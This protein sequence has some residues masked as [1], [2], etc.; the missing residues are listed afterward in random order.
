M[1]GDVHSNVFLEENGQRHLFS[2][3]EERKE[4]LLR[5]LLGHA[6]HEILHDRHL[7]PDTRGEVFM[8]GDRP[9]AVATAVD[10]RFAQLVKHVLTKLGGEGRRQGG[11]ESDEELLLDILNGG[12]ESV[13]DLLSLLAGCRLV[14]WLTRGARGGLEVTHRGGD[15]IAHDG[16]QV[17]DEGREVL[18]DDDGGALDELVD[19]A[20]GG[21]VCL[22]V[23][24]SARGSGSESVQPCRPLGLLGGGDTFRG[25]RSNHGCRRLRRRP[26]RRRLDCSLGHRLSW[27]ARDGEGGSL[28]Q[29]DGEQP[30]GNRLCHG[31]V[32]L[33]AEGLGPSGERVGSG[34]SG[35]GGGL[36]PRHGA[37]HRRADVHAT[38]A[39]LHLPVVCYR[40]DPQAHARPPPVS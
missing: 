20:G 38:L 8:R 23:S 28:L 12:V 6:H 15:P 36:Q 17:L 27:G 5:P 26:G 30:A 1:L 4:P 24:S 37:R 19:P 9:E 35:G 7:L 31:D 2:L 22:H 40:R 33:T 32:D 25:R 11:A 18:V 13:E 16:A 3:E 10:R 29:S 14:E 21:G 39:R 34:G